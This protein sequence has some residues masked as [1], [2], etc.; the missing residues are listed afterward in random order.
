MSANEAA[1]RE[2][3]NA[4]LDRRMFMLDDEACLK[5]IDR[6]DAPPRRNEKLR[7]LLTTKVPWEVMLK[8]AERRR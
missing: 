5:F 7:R 4:L 6:F 2:A 3:E 1:R 8:S